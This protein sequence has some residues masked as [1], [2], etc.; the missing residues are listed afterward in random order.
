VR[1]HTEMFNHFF[2]PLRTAGF[3]PTLIFDIGAYEG[4]FIDAC[5]SSF[6]AAKCW[7][8]E[9]NL[10]KQDALSRKAERVFTD[11]LGEAPG[12]VTYW[13]ADIPEQSG[14][15]I[16]RENTNIGFR[17]TRR[18]MI[19]IDSLVG[20]QVPS[21]VKLD[22]QGSELDILKGG[23]NSLCLAEVI[24]V[25]VHIK[26]NNEGAPLFHEVVA[27]LDSVGF[28]FVDM[29]DALRVQGILV[30]SDALF[31]KRTTPFFSESARVEFRSRIQLASA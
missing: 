7:A 10:A 25:E 22:T 3:A 21:L 31:V 5:R 6:P 4:A 26:R 24:L 18:R 16:R 20:R 9:P 28:G 27:Y 1:G 17:P 8:F 23:R 29:S 15:S 14:N 13:E 12:E 30:Q 2:D 11:V 19:D